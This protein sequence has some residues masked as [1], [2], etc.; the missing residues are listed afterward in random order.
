MQTHL[1]SGAVQQ[2]GPLAHQSDDFKAAFL[3]L[4]LVHGRYRTPGEALPA[5]IAV[6]TARHDLPIS[7][8]LPCCSASRVAASVRE[9][10]TR[11]QLS[12]VDLIQCHDIEFTQLDQVSG[13]V[14][15]CASSG[16]NC[17]VHPGWQPPLCRPLTVCV[18]LALCR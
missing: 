18:C 1:T 9:S 16:S 8:P 10:L 17:H 7:R 11:L 4:L 13:C 15:P 3:S 12:Y 14:L 2:W 5:R 6:C